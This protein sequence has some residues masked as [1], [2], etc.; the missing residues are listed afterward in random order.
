MDGQIKGKSNE[1]SVAIYFNHLDE[2][3]LKT[4]LMVTKMFYD[5]N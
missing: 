2:R 1:K 3:N 4:R 5:I